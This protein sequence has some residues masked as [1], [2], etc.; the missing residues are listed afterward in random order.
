MNESFFTEFENKKQRIYQKQLELELLETLT[1]TLLWIKDYVEKYNIPIPN[2]ENL[3]S[4]LRKANVLIEELSRIPTDKF[5]EPVTLRHISRKNRSLELGLY[6][7]IR[8]NA[9]YLP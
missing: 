6:I 4:L 8:K 2:A 5:T 1:V 3:A 9:E 7:K